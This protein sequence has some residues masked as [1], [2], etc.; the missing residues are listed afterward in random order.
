M[1]YVREAQ[2]CAGGIAD[3]QW[4]AVDAGL[5]LTGLHVVPLRERSE[6]KIRPL[7]ACSTWLGEG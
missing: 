4:H 3:G 6:K 7:T 2:G 1:V 5:R